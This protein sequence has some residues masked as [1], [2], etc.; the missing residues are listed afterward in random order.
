[1]ASRR[2]T[3]LLDL[4]NELLEHITEYLEL[5]PDIN[6][7]CQTNRR[8]YGLFDNCLY[9]HNVAQS[10]SSALLWAAAVGRE[11]T[12]LKLLKEGANVHTTNRLQKTPLFLAAQNGHD[13]VLQLLLSVDGIDADAQNNE[14]LTPLTLAAI[15]GHKK[16]VE[17][18]LARYDVDA[19]HS[20]MGGIGPSPLSYAALN[21]QE[22]VV[23]LLLATG[24]VD[25]N[26]KDMMLETPL[27]FAA[28]GGHVG[29][30]KLP[31]AQEGIDPDPMDDIH[32]TPLSI[33]TAHRHEEV[34][35][36]LLDRGCV[37]P[38][39]HDGWIPPPPYLEDELKGRFVSVHQRDTRRTS[40]SRNGQSSRRGRDIS[41]VLRDRRRVRKHSM[42][43]IEIDIDEE[44]GDIRASAEVVCDGNTSVR[45]RLPSPNDQERGSEF[46]LDMIV[47][48]QAIYRI[49]TRPER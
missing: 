33:A 5:E 9:R 12:V 20:A 4:P 19:D 39:R 37:M 14:E 48:D 45:T 13:A 24:R 28:E 43:E 27:Y 18:L 1:M 26:F 49:K 29:V 7:L 38:D 15:G 21:G 32:R 16:V 34:V 41:G 6:V 30:V 40:R 11:V 36:L 31:L 22:D 17:L 8:L 42:G 10:G 47:H 23:S 46:N 25:P 35:K 2:E 3:S 44:D